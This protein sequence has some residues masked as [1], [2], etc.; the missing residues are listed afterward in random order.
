VLSL[1][2]TAMDTEVQT[3]SMMLTESST[4]VKVDLLDEY[5]NKLH[6]FFMVNQFKETNNRKTLELK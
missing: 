3:E 4:T 2:A 1:A 5:D 6:N